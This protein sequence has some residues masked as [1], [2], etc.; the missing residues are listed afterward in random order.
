ME[1]LVEFDNPAYLQASKRSK[2]TLWKKENHA[3]YLCQMN[4]K[5]RERGM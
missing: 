1:K 2:E 5:K 3:V 4:D